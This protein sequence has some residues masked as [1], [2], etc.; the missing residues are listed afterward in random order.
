MKRVPKHFVDRQR[1]LQAAAEL[2]IWKRRLNGVDGFDWLATLAEWHERGHEPPHMLLQLA[3]TGRQVPHDA[4]DRS[5]V[6]PQAMDEYI[7][8]IVDALVS[9]EAT[10]VTDQ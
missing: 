5:G 1:D 8:Q 7:Q 10:V 6:E 4:P 9:G 2:M 3:R